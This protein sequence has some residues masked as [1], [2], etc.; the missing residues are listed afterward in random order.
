[1]RGIGASLGGGD[2]TRTEDEED[3]GTMGVRHWQDAD[4]G[5]IVVARFF[6][7]RRRRAGSRGLARQAAKRAASLRR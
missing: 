7:V 6:L 4:C 1:M 2:I 5:H 3:A